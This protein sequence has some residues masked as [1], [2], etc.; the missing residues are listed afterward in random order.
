MAQHR[1]FGD[2][3]RFAAGHICQRCGDQDSGGWLD[4]LFDPT[5]KIVAE[6]EKKFEHAGRVSYYL[7]DC[8]A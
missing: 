2:E 3:V 1:V 5:A 7:I 4:P 8:P 6:N